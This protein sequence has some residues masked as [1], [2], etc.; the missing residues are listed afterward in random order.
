M[1]SL[2]DR[3]LHAVS[4]VLP[5][6]QREDILAELHED[7]SS[8]LEERQEELG[9][10]LNDDEIAA[11]LKKR[12]HP[13]L[14][15]SRY[16]P[17]QYLIGPLYPA[18]V[19]VLKL[20]LLWGIIPWFVLTAPIIYAT[21]GNSAAAMFKVLT[22][23]P[24]ALFTAFGVI[25]LIFAVCE[26]AWVGSMLAA[27]SN[28]DPRKLPDVPAYPPRDRVLRSTSVGELISG[29]FWTGLWL[30]M[31]VH[32]FSVDI[33]GVHC[34]LPGIWREV[35][36]PELVLLGAGIALGVILLTKPELVRAYAITRI[37]IDCGAILVAAVLFFPGAAVAIS[38]PQL[39]AE[40]V[41]HAQYGVAL[42]LRIAWISLT[43]L[44]LVDMLVQIARLRRS[45]STPAWGMKSALSR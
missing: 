37:S 24:V 20:V 5:G 10:D 40:A 18:Y 6:E 11:V 26:K 14:V 43:V 36:W 30:Y 19:F 15:A 9:R 27:W 25:T 1:K 2:V 4:I 32:G 22:K 34:S 42:G 21:S 38:G 23:L 29:V 12:G 7:I 13:T 44:F 45:R 17:Q 35:F 8:Q 31:A 3:Y 16:L 39:S 28:W 41:A 33:L